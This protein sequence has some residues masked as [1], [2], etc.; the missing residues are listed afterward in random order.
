M[1]LLSYSLQT[2]HAAL[3]YPTPATMSTEICCYWLLL[4]TEMTTKG[5]Q[6]VVAQFLSLEKL[7]WF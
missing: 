4:M 3:S 5:L 2:E 6:N 1:Q 7:A